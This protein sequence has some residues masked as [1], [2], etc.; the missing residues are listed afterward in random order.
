LEQYKLFL[1]EYG[2]S[3][4][5]D[6]DIYFI[7]RA[8]DSSVD[9]RL[10]AA[11]LNVD[12]KNHARSREKMA[13]EKK[14]AAFTEV[15]ALG[16]L[17]T[18]LFKTLNAYNQR[19]LSLRDDERGFIDLSTFTYKRCFLEINRRLLER[20]VFQDPLDFYFLSRQELYDV[21]YER[22]SMPLARAKIAGRR[23]NFDLVN[24]K[25]LDTVLFIQFD[26]PFEP[27]EIQQ[28]G[29]NL[30]GLPTSGGII[31]GRATLIKH[32]ERIDQVQQVTL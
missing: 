14:R 1:K 5:A 13:L 25:E 2:H 23:R 18:A 4:H 11:F 24:S 17:K 10:L 32:L 22:A 9:Y 26:R 30:S 31:T 29:S 19:L 7:R 8:E 28:D 27:V 3:G 12:A 21:F 16:A 20:E 6:R 15:V